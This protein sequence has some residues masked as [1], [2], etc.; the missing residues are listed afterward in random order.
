MVGGVSI[1]E[2]YN[3]GGHRVCRPTG[4][5]RDSSLRIDKAP[6]MLSPAGPRSLAGSKYR[7]AYVPKPEPP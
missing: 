5:L 7:A 2:T 1:P 6:G 4:L 3:V